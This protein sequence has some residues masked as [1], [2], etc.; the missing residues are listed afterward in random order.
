MSAG[1]VGAESACLDLAWQALGAG[2]IP[3]GS[4]V[5]DADGVIVSSG[6]NAVFGSA[7]PPLVRGSLLAL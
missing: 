5:V 4:V 6:R 3:V 1:V 7:E 2:T